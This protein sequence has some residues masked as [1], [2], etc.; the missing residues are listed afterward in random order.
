MGLVQPR[1]HVLDEE[2]FDEVV[3]V[4]RADRQAQRVT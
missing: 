3:E 2:P 1:R 4:E